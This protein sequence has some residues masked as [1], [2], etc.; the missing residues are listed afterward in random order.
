MTLALIALIS[1]AT[2]AFGHTFFVMVITLWS[3]V[4]QIAGVFSI[5]ASAGVSRGVSTMNGFV[6]VAPSIES[7]GDLP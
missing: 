7:I 2:L 1:L 5:I 4:I 6:A 3:L